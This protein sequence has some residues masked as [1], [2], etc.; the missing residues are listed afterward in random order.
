MN[1]LM[2]GNNKREKKKSKLFPVA[3][4]EF[5]L[6]RS[7]S[8][9]TIKAFGVHP[10]EKSRRI[11]EICDSVGSYSAP[12]HMDGLWSKAFFIC[13]CDPLSGRHIFDF[14]CLNKPEYFHGNT[15]NDMESCFKLQSSS[16][17]GPEQALINGMGVA[18]TCLWWE[19]TEPEN[20]IS[21]YQTSTFSS[22]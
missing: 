1:C 11:T 7:S 9:L 19:R 17:R 21:A 2:W 6:C 18:H 4:L 22:L 10:T 8:G 20:C 5:L 3:V 13:S 12:K 15:H 16:T 14:E